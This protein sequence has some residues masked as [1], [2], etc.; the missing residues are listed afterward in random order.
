MLGEIRL[1]PYS[2]VPEGWHACDGSLLSTDE[3]HALYSLLGTAY[4]GDG[5]NNFALPNLTQAGPLA[6]QGHGMYCIA[7]WGLYPSRT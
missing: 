5:Q 7:I 6:G 1:F 2:F 3:Y 4:G